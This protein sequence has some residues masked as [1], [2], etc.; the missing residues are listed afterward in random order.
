[1]NIHIVHILSN[2][3]HIKACRSMYYC[4][5]MSQIMVVNC[6]WHLHYWIFTISVNFVHCCEI[7]LHVLCFCRKN[8]ERIIQISNEKLPDVLE[9]A[10]R[11]VCRIF[12]LPYFSQWWK[13]ITCLVSKYFECVRVSAYCIVSELPVVKQHLQL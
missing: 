4:L 13:P 11:N 3:Y 7:I 1:M 10:K 9:K 12:Y 8:G 5:I 6:S 2:K